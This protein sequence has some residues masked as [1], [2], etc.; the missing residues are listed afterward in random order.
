MSAALQ[1]FFDGQVSS[2]Y[3]FGSVGSRKTSIA[4]AALR[5]WYGLGKPVGM[6]G[7][8][9]FVTEETFGRVLRSFDIADSYRQAWAES[10]I[11][12]ID[13][14][15][16]VRMTPLLLD[17]M[18]VLLKHRYGKDLATICTSNLTLPELARAMDPRIASRM[19]E[20][21]VL[22]LGDRDKRRMVPVRETQT[23]GAQPQGD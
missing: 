18:I 12:V 20:G 9:R 2:V 6:S 23:A 8:T 5:R 13:D 21:I 19:Q 4:A 17:A 1:P 11:L 7:A 15:G 14:L 16:A 22:D 3:L 10:P